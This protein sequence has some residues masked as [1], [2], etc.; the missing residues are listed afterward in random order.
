MAAALLPPTTSGMGFGQPRINPYIVEVDV[1]TMK[2]GICGLQQ[3]ADRS[4]VLVGEAPALREI[5]TQVFV[6][7]AAYHLGRLEKMAAT[8]SDRAGRHR[9][10]G[11]EVP[12]RLECDR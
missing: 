10:S 6:L 3:S 1:L 4:D 2:S 12:G 5:G 7:V 9:Q 11:R 8:C